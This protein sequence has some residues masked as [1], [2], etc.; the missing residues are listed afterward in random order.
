[1]VS[2]QMVGMVGKNLPERCLGFEFDTEI[3]PEIDLVT[4]CSP[5]KHLPL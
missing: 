3:D 2:V 1:M 4:W 5:K